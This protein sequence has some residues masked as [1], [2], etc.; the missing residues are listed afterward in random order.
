MAKRLQVEQIYEQDGKN[1]EFDFA[2]IMVKI[3]VK[4]AVGHLSLE[5]S[6]N[7]GMYVCT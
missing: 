1:Q 2:H 5:F 6:L 3:D 4:W 7:V